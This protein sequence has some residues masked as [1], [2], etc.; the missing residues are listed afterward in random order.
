MNF[1]V[2][3]YDRIGQLLLDVREFHEDDRSSAKPMRF[4]AQRKALREHLDQEIVL[5][6]ASSR[7][8][9]E[10][11]HGSYFLSERELLERAKE[12]AEAS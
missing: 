10:R 2:L 3:V 11:W 4:D 6:Q 12:A 8:A 9:P 7:G 5:F 1:F